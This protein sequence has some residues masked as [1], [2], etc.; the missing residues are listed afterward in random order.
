MLS[1]NY[2]VQDTDLNSEIKDD[3]K[4]LIFAGVKDSLDE[5]QLSNLDQFIMKGGNLLVFQDGVDAELQT[6]SAKAINSN[7][8]DLLKNYGV[9]IN[10]DIVTD[11][12]CNSVQIQRMQGFFRIATPVQ[13]PPLVVLNNVNK[14]SEIVKRL[15]QMQLI[16]ASSIDTTKVKAGVKFT[17]LLYTSNNSGKI[18]GPKYDI[19]YMKFMKKNLKEMLK[20][21]P[22]IV[23]GLYSGKFKSYFDN[24]KESKP[25]N[26]I[27]LTDSDFITELGAAKNQ[28]NIDFCLNSTDYL[29]G[30]ELLIG[31]RSRE[32]Q[33]MPLKDLKPATRRLVKWINV[34]LSSVLLVL[35]GILHYK[36]ELK[37]R[38]RIGERYE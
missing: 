23:A 5:K 36:S 1:K 34:L 37:R 26:I 20:D 4:A 33:Y 2:E 15:D 29:S 28:S 21:K 31:L 3:V 30:N 7:F 25:A 6:Q 8:L 13:Y 12:N 9:K 16:F 10:S 17:P 11:A 32:V 14:N 22:Y 24:T 27:V 38:K 19:G 18:R 35:F